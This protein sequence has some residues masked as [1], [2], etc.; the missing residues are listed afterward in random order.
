MDA[1]SAEQLKK[2]QAGGNSALNSFL[3]EY[4]VEKTLA[5]KDKYTCRAA[6]VHHASSGTTFRLSV[7]IYLSES[8]SVGCCF[9]SA[10]G[11]SKDSEG[12]FLQA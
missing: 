1:W 3:K 6:E 4:G 10:H 2:M 8:W 7:C 12:D 9:S 5:V 11:N